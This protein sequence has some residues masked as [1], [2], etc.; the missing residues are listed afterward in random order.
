MPTSS[1]PSFVS[2]LRKK[3]AYPEPVSKIRFHE[4]VT[5]YLF[6]A[7]EHFYKV[8]K[9]DSEYSNLAVKQAFCHEEAKLLQRFNAEDLAVEVLP[10]S[11]TTDGFVLGASE[12]ATVVEYALRTPAL[13]ERNLVSHLLEQKKLS[14]IAVGRI[15]RKLAQVHTDNPAPEKVAHERGRPEVLRALCEDMLY[16]MKRHFDESFTQPIQDMI[17]HPLEKFF[18]EQARLFPRR[19][20]KRRIVEGHGALL[21][22]HIH[23]KGPVVLF[24]SPQEVQKKYAILDAS[25]DVATFSVELLRHQEE[26]LNL[27]FID[28]YLRSSRDRADMQLILPVYQMYSAL[29]LGIGQ[30]EARTAMP[31]SEEERQEFQQRAVQYFNLAVRFARQLQH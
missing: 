16:Q 30:C 6:K 2:A 3:E 19:I 23:I 14:L 7:G 15:A 10:V 13:V 31:W 27:S 12:G 4:T 28:R 25:H 29:R 26:E 20:R 18:E 9:T 11:Q 8:K 1:Y 21:P 22:D 17:R 5:S 24:L